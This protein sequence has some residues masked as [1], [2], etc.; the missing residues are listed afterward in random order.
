MSNGKIYLVKTAVS[1]TFL[2]QIEEVLFAVRNAE[3]K[4]QAVEKLTEGD[5]ARTLWVDTEHVLDVTEVL[6]VFFNLEDNMA[7][8][9]DVLIINSELLHKGNEKLR[10]Y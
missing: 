7:W 10:E 8:M 4:E 5:N 2:N 9:N 3:S 1:Y 6:P